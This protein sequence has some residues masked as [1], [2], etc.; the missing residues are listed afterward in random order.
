MVEDDRLGLVLVLVI[1]GQMRLVHLVC[2]FMA[3]SWLN[4]LAR[5]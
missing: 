1:V 2:M 3:R 4:D 5:R